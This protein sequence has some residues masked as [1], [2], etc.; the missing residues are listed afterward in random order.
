LSTHFF[1]LMKVF[2][3][4][5]ALVWMGGMTFFWL[6]Y[7][8]DP[9]PLSIMSLALSPPPSVWE[10]R[11][12]GQPFCSF[13]ELSFSILWPPHL[14]PAMLLSSVPSFFH[15]LGPSPRLRRRPSFFGEI[16]ERMTFLILSSHSLFS[17]RF[18]RVP[19]TFPPSSSYAN[20]AHS[21][22][23]NRILNRAPLFCPFFFPL[24]LLLAFLQ[25]LRALSSF[26]YISPP[27]FY[28]LSCRR[29]LCCRNSFRREFFLLRV[30]LFFL[31]F[32]PFCGPL[33]S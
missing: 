4:P 3:P 25:E 7:K 23:L 29:Q 8:K 15:S 22:R 2:F 21:S 27:F 17:E 9:C 28:P 31:L 11:S 12:V 32:S 19:Y 6:V 14:F 13:C 20:T 24:C 10:I 5:S 1:F 33:H 30:H 16:F 18:L 26:F